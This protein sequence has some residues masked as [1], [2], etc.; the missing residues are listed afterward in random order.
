MLHMLYKAFKSICA[1]MYTVSYGLSFCEKFIS[2]Q[3]PVYYGFAS[4]LRNIGLVVF[5]GVLPADSIC[6]CLWIPGTVDA[7]W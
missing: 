3:C 1:Q 2:G 5:L 6:L 7:V 4:I